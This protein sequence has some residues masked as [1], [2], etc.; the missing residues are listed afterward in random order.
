MPDPNCWLFASS[1]ANSWD[2]PDL[3]PAQSPVE[4]LKNKCLELPISQDVGHFRYT[5]DLL[6]LFV[7]RRT[8]LWVNSN[9]SQKP[10]ACLFLSFRSHIFVWSDSGLF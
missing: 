10:T 2:Q 4:T 1:N 6:C 3:E 5:T 7:Q 9:A 8:C